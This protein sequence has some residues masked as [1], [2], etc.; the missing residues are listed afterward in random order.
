[1]EKRI[2]TIQVSWK[3]PVLLNHCTL[4]LV[5]LPASMTTP[6]TLIADKP[7]KATH[8]IRTWSCL[9]SQG[10][11]PRPLP[12][13]SSGVSA[14]CTQ[15]SPVLF[16]LWTTSMPLG[17][18]H[19]QEQKSFSHLHDGLDDECNSLLCHRCCRKELCNALSSL[20]F[21]DPFCP[22][23]VLTLWSQRK[24]ISTH[25][26]LWWGMWNSICDEKHWLLATAQ[27]LRRCVEWQHCLCCDCPI[28]RSTG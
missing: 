28:D 12:C 27:A 13:M 15:R 18:R 17:F 1:M 8:Q 16:A 24:T 10:H 26:M 23:R 7:S 19:A 6:T 25:T 11:G 4:K 20:L 22:C 9:F 21:Q 3:E 2:G 5:S 14:L